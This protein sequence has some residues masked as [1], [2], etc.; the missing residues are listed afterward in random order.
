M[1][2]TGGHYAAWA[3][4]LENWAAG[5]NPDP[6]ALPAI[7][8][9]DLHGD[10]WERFVLRLTDALSQRLQAGADLLSR[11]LSGARDEFQAA[12]AM[13]DARARLAPIRAVA[14]HPGLPGE[15]RQRLVDVTE[16]RVRSLQTSLEDQIVR[17][18][19]T[20]T[21]RPAVEARLRTVRENAITTTPAAPGGG[22]DIAP[23]HRPMRRVII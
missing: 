22:W 4:F 1:Y 11:E 16:A 19:R 6:A 12:R 7:A 14:G 5:A 15:L 8:D 10:N 23:T 21:P 20:G 17:L 13:H 2:A 3:A 18:E 9:D